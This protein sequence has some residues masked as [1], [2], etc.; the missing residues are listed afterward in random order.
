MRGTQDNALYHRAPLR[1][2]SEVG[3]GLGQY[4]IYADWINTLSVDDEYSMEALDTNLPAVPQVLDDRVRTP[5]ADFDTSPPYVVHQLEWRLGY[6]Y[7][8][9]AERYDRYGRIAQKAQAL[10]KS[11]THTLNVLAHYPLNSA[12]DTTVL[13]GWNGEPLASNAHTLIGGATYDNY[14]PA[15]APG[16]ALFADAVDYFENM[17]DEQGFKMRGGVRAIV[18]GTE[19]AYEWAQFFGSNTEIGQSNPNVVNPYPQRP[20]VIASPYLENSTRQIFLGENHRINLEIGQQPT[21][22]TVDI[23][24]PKAIMHRVEMDANVGVLDQREILVV[25]GS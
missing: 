7:T 25:A 10:G 16:Q 2:I 4:D 21:F 24:D 17:P 8:R 6:S 11:V 23:P 13:W 12:E 5:Q 15:A 9:R 20:V 1:A 3:M 19:Y 22:D 14:L 18:T